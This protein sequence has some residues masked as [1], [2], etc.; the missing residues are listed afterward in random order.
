MMSVIPSL[1]I[2]STIRGSAKFDL[3][4][5]SA[6]QTFIPVI[7]NSLMQNFLSFSGMQLHC[8]HGVSSFIVHCTDAY[9]NENT[10][11]QL[12]MQLRDFPA[13]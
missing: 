6:V 10:V 13:E 11:D 5:H 12:D 2:V 9:P 1:R 8:G 7:I 3:H 4:L